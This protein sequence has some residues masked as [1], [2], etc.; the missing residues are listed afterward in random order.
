MAADYEQLGVFYLG[1]E[2]DAATGKLRDEKV[3]YDSRD[4]TTHAVCMGMTGSGKTGLCLALLEEA[5][6][7]GVAAICIDP[8][9]DLGNLL[10]TFPELAP[11]QFEPWVDAGEAARKGVPVAELA[12]S[13]ASTWR[14]GLAEWEQDGDRIARLRA[15]ADIAI[16]TPGADD[17]LPL[18]I[19]SSLE[20]RGNDGASDRA[21]SFASSLLTLLR[22]EAD[23]LQNPEH[24]LLAA[25]LQ[26]AWAAG[27]K[28]DLA[29]LIALVQKPP[30][31]QL[32]AMDVESVLPAKERRA[33]AM[34]INNLIAAPSFAPWTRGAPLDAQQLLFTPQG[35]PRIAIVSISHLSDEE[36][37][38]FVTLLLDEIIAWMRRQPGTSSLL[39]IL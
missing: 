38:F 7:D 26:N 19:L 11:T 9:G 3:L 16:Y 10:L 39:A 21:A 32:G 30:F 17:G 36:R 15:A 33:L 34:A 29:A 13:V 12:A 31:D 20:A 22:R 14:K 35:K 8:K 23:P 25:I 5:A 28:L 6:L 2:F 18:S 1:R 27:Q 4:L 37:M 24:T